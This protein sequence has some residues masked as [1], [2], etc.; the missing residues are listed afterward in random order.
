MRGGRE[1]ERLHNDK[2]LQNM[3]NTKIEKIWEMV[4]KHE[5]MCKNNM[6]NLGE[7]LRKPGK[8]RENMKMPA[9]I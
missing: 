1:S 9:K 6:K 3:D 2:T 5:K 8:M 4:R 7:N